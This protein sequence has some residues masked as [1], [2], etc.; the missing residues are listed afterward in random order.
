MDTSKRMNEVDP[1]QSPGSDFTTTF[2]QPPLW[3]REGFDSPE[4]FENFMAINNE[5]LQQHMCHN[6]QNQPSSSRAPRNADATPTASSTQ[7]S[8][9]T[10]QPSKAK[11][12]MKSMYAKA[13]DKTV[14]FIDEALLSPGHPDKSYPNALAPKREVQISLP[15]QDETWLE[16]FMNATA[17]DNAGRTLIP[18]ENAQQL[19]REQA[20]YAGE[21]WNRTNFVTDKDGVERQRLHSTKELKEGLLNG[22][23]AYVGGRKPQPGPSS[24]VPKPRKPEAGPSKSSSPAQAS[25]SA[26]ASRTL[27][28]VP[29][30]H[31]AVDAKKPSPQAKV[32]RRKIDS[33]WGALIDAANKAP[34]NSSEETLAAAETSE[35]ARRRRVTVINSQTFHPVDRD[36]SA[37]VAQLDFSEDED[38][39]EALNFS[40]PPAE[41]A[42]HSSDLAAETQRLE[43]IHLGHRFAPSSDDP[44]T[45]VQIDTHIR[46][47]HVSWYVRDEGAQSSRHARQERT[48]P[49]AQS[50][51]REEDEAARLW[52]RLE[53][54]QHGAPQSLRKTRR[55]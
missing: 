12:V 45:T 44:D 29:V 32:P 36:S 2:G 3:R 7:T 15:I 38:E 6:V 46:D 5:R 30:N 16:N 27:P 54:E 18:I 13:K 51:V 24:R 53:E 28:T 47:G 50:H 17:N 33:T 8:S 49:T 35:R 4:E 42:H 39:D 14:K 41:P 10:R 37:N 31:S 11:H 22:T 26:E 9:L 34:S 40:S 48:S 25:S 1:D 21:H 20:R 23:V 43:S 52:K 55:R 19:R